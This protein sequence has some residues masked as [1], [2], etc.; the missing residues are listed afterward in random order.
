MVSIPTFGALGVVDS[1][2]R[3]LIMIDVENSD[4]AWSFY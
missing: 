3:G 2:N 4:V 1:Q